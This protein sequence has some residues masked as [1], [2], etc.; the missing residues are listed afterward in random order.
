MNKSTDV[1][2]QQV[3]E[4]TL[5]KNLWELVGDGGAI[6]GSFTHRDQA[7]RYADDLR[8]LRKLKITLKNPE[9]AV[10][11]ETDKITS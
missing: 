11:A 3:E 4:E 7:E 8:R 5:K 10:A 9:G 1:Q 6:F 2:S